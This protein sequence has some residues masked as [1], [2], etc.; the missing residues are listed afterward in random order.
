MTYRTAKNKSLT[1]RIIILVILIIILILISFVIYTAITRQGIVLNQ[2]YEGHLKNYK[3]ELPME[4]SYQQDLKFI[5]QEIKDNYVNLKY[6][7]KLL[8]FDWDEQY[9]FYKGQLDKVSSKKDFYKICNEFITTLK[10]GHVWFEEYNTDPDL[11]F[12][13]PYSKGFVSAFELRY[14]EDHP[15][16]VSNRINSSLNGYEIVSINEVPFSDI[17]NSMLKYCYQRGNDNSAKAY[18]LRSAE[19]YRYFLYEYD[20]YPKKLTF[21]LMNKDGL[22]KN[23]NISTDVSFDKDYDIS[24]DINLGLIDNG[25]PTYK[26]LNDIGYIRIDTFD[27]NIK[28]IVNTFR[29]IVK[30]LKEANVKGVV[31]DLRNNGGG[32]ESFRKIL[33]YLTKGE[34]VIANYHYRKSERFDDIYYLRPLFDTLS[35]RTSDLTAEKGYTNWYKWTVKPAK[36]QFLTSIPVALLINESIFSSTNDF[37]YTCLKYNLAEVIGNTVPLSGFGLSTQVVLPSSQYVMSYC[38]FESV[39]PEGSP[40][41]NVVIEPDITVNQTCDD[42]IHNKDT[43]LDTAVRY[44]NDMLIK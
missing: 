7:E 6:K 17:I 39:T 24:S 44:M 2:P 40:L 19:F 18:L 22:K 33:S 5:Y 41:E 26:I 31:L 43:Q 20:T 28:E 1:G 14:I 11:R 23:I 42:L 10:D 29:D 16:I 8:H 4:D 9:E 30:T 34:I 21:E 25:L 36:E 37:V 13:A 12:W 38:F 3:T 35:G 15:I 32:N 27:G